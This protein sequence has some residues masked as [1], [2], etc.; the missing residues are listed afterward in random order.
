M[1]EGGGARPRTQSFPPCRQLP[2]LLL[3]VL[4]P[5]HYI[6]AR[7]KFE[8]PLTLPSSLWSGTWLG[9]ALGHALWLSVPTYELARSSL[10]IRR[11]R[12]C[13][14]SCK[15]VSCWPGPQRALPSPSILCSKCR[16]SAIS[17]RLR[18]SRFP[19]DSRR[20]SEHLPLRPFLPMTIP[21]ASSTTFSLGSRWPAKRISGT[22]S[23]PVASLFA[24]RQPLLD[25]R[26]MVRVPKCAAHSC[27][28]GH[29]LVLFRKRLQ[30]AGASLVTFPLLG[31]QKIYKQP[32][33]GPK[34][35]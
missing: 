3:C 18:S 28:D 17:L 25:L 14:Q 6:H 1:L 13:V 34:N 9:S 35:P 7:W 24:R 19:C 16:E 31:C 11:H 30:V 26:T 12:S 21:R 33:R 23:V 2:F 10:S 5:L 4:C 20:T 15:S 32:G 8:C 29:A 22:L 27:L